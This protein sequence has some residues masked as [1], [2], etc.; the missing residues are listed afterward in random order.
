MEEP[1]SAPLFSLIGQIVVVENV[2]SHSNWNLLSVDPIC[3]MLNYLELRRLKLKHTWQLTP[4][5]CYRS[6]MAG[7]LQAVQ[8][9]ITMV[10][11]SSCLRTV[12]AM[13]KWHL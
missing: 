7:C 3:F 12:R 6:S 9:S 1:K 13:P 2:W 5:F 4:F 8:I 10:V 11:E